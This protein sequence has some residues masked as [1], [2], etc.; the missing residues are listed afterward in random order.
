MVPEIHSFWLSLL[1]IPKKRTT[2]MYKRKVCLQK[3]IL[4]KYR[5][6]IPNKQKAQ[7]PKKH[8]L[9]KKIGAY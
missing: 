8:L 3:N 4:R 7:K 2:L 5:R 1:K 9:E 6:D